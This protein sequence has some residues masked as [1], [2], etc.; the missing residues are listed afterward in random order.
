MLAEVVEIFPEGIIE[1]RRILPG[2]ARVLA[3]KG[4]VVA[5]TDIIAEDS[6]SARHLFIDTC[7]GLGITEQNVAEH[8]HC[9]VGQQ[10]L[11]KDVL[12]G[13]LGLTRRLVRSPSDGTVVLVERGK[14][15]LELKSTLRTLK[16]GL[17]GEVVELIPGQGAVIRGL[18]ALV[19]GVWGNGIINNGPLVIDRTDAIQDVRPESFKTVPPQSVIMAENCRDARVLELAE[20]ASLGGI[21]L[22]WLSPRLIPIAQALPLP[23]LVLE[24]FYPSAINPLARQIFTHHQNELISV[25]AE[26]DRVRS[27]I[28]PEVIIKHSGP[29]LG[30][31]EIASKNSPSRSP[32][33]FIQGMQVRPLRAPYAGKVGVLVELLGQVEFLNSYHCQAGLVRLENNE[34]ATIPLVNLELLK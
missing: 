22:G 29:S 8:I 31:A 14:I 24:G 27:G 19:Q 2:N 11:E 25:N 26:M 23:V 13:P 28:R 12:A 17:P 10:V 3:R 32:E 4:Q 5:A 16:A 34:I 18:G 7:R 1:R 20:Q 9:H 6:Q 15:L 33:T 21:I 30:G